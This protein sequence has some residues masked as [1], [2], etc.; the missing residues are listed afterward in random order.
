MADLRASYRRAAEQI[1]WW[2]WRFHLRWE[3]L[4]RPEGIW[5]IWVAA[6]WKDAKE[7]WGIIF[8]FLN[9]LDGRELLGAVLTRF[10]HAPFTLIAA[11]RNLGIKIEGVINKKRRPAFLVRGIFVTEMIYVE[12]P[13]QNQ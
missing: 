4:N 2:Q 9:L 6:F 3:Q 12:P 11:L 1:H 13:T 10:F 7:G 5:G 8:C